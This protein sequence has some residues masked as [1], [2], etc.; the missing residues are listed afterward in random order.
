MLK[1]III[2]CMTCA[3]FCVQADICE[4]PKPQVLELWPFDLKV[5]GH[6]V[7]WTALLPGAALKKKQIHY[8]NEKDSPFAR[9]GVKADLGFYEPGISISIEQKTETA[10]LLN[11]K[12]CIITTGAVLHVKHVAEIQLAKE[13]STESCVAKEAMKYQLINHRLAVE[14][15]D[16]MNTKEGREL[17]KKAVF[18]SFQYQGATGGSDQGLQGALKRQR[19]Q[20]SGVVIGMILP[21][22]A[23]MRKQKAQTR[24][25]ITALQNSC[26]G[27]FAEASERVGN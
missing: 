15:V 12:D 27:D 1:K 19:D 14:L 3:S 13:L 26:N 21:R 24:Q 10:K 2:C 23:M 25:N 16:S 7:A 8:F 9:K 11:G 5:D 22:L 6:N 17:I 18:D 4:A 20:A